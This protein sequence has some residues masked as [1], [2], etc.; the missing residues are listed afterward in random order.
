MATMQQLTGTS[1]TPQA[2]SALTQVSGVGSANYQSG[3][4]LASDLMKIMGEGVKTAQTYYT[5]SKEAA[6]RVASDKNV[7]LAEFISNVKGTINYDDPA[8]LAEA[9]KEIALKQAELS[10]VEFELTDAQN[11]FDDTYTKPAAMQVGALN[12]QLKKQE[13]I[14]LDDI[15]YDDIKLKAELRYT[16]NVYLSKEEIQANVDSA[17]AYKRF[18]K[19]DVEYT[20]ATK[21]TTAFDSKIKD[22]AKSVLEGVGY[23]P[24]KG[25]TIEVKRKLFNKEFG[26]WGKMQKDGTIKWDEDYENRAKD[27]ILRAWSSF[28]SRMSEHGKD[29]YNEKFYL[30]KSSG[31]KV[32]SNASSNYIPSANIK[33]NTK[34]IQEK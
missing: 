31:D 13:L 27:E 16:N 9:Q 21:N 25:W 5:A 15:N 4:S 19:E 26:A 8:S 34:Q 12:A 22:G 24:N 7:E 32:D 18:D 30:T 17:T 11:S 14:K 23:D 3:E 29:P 20:I 33:E 6:K 1:P 10:D 28:D 2:S